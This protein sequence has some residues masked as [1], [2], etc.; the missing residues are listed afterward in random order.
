MLNFNSFTT[1][2]KFI[3]LMCDEATTV[4]LRRLCFVND[5]DLTK[6]YDGN[7]IDPSE[8]CFHT[9]IIFSSNADTLDV[10]VS[11]LPVNMATTIL[12]TNV[13]GK[14][15]NIP[16]LSLNVTDEMYH[17]RQYITKAYNLTDPWPEWHAHLSLS[18]ATKVK[19][20]WKIDN[21]Q[22]DF[23]IVFDRLEVSDSE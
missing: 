13:L 11:R 23:P 18:Y 20:D 3:G 7:Q 10:G 21:I 5:L 12:S 6:D 14:Q 19:P 17:L 1:A 9:T 16:V 2:K 15:N 4:N 8:F 22:L